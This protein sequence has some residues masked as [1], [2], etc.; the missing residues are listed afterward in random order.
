M[1]RVLTWVIVAGLSGAC[2]T[3]ELA[4]SDK[5]L[6]VVSVLPQ[7]YVVERIAAD[8]VDVEAL[9]PPGAIPEIYEPSMKQMKALEEA[10]LYVRVGH[11]AFAFERVWI[12]PL[13]EEMPGLQIVDASEGVELVGMDPHVWLSP[14]NTER[15]ARNAAAALIGLVPSERAR[16]RA[17]LE[18][19]V[20][21]IASLDQEIRARL[22]PVKGGAFLVFHPAWGYFAEEYGL[23]QLAIE[24]EHKEPDPR[25]LAELLDLAGEAGADV[26]FVQ[27]QLDPARAESVA[28]ELDARILTLDPL[29]YDWSENLREVSQVLARE[30]GP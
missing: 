15:M 8:L 12:D 26:V 14:A 4:R 18:S 28:R 11:P 19:F 27:P 17:G 21:E 7:K 13:L 25:E 5:A 23:V 22:E 29:A 30:L 10:S 3:G 20:E 1:K 2:G 24:H 9:I 6:V 16:I